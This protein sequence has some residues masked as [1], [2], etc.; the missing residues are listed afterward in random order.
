MSVDKSL[1]V[2][3]QCFF[4]P[5]L[6]VWIYPTEHPVE[7]V[8]SPGYFNGVAT[9]LGPMDVAEHIIYLKGDFSVGV[10]VTRVDARSRQVDVEL[11]QTSAGMPGQGIPSS[12][13]PAPLPP[14]RGPGRPPGA[15]NKPKADSSAAAL[16]T[17]AD[18]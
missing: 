3:G 12:P 10:R 4:C 9:F 18:G 6:A 13:V 17:V 7:A 14:R 5:S 16:A 8:L 11:I 15:K 2:N 1:L